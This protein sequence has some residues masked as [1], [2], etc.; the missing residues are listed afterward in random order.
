MDRFFQLANFFLD[1]C[2][3]C[4]YSLQALEGEQCP[5]CGAG[6]K[7]PNEMIKLDRTGQQLLWA[8]MMI[9]LISLIWFGD[10]ILSFLMEIS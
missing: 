2:A 3:N 9:G 7:D 5:E 6:G 4:D 1:Q 8:L 10:E